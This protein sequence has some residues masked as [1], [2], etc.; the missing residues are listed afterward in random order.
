MNDVSHA[1]LVKV[2]SDVKCETSKVVNDLSL[3]VVN[4]V[5][6]CIVTL[7]NKGNLLDNSGCS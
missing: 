1:E 4:I 3:R 2:V 5:F 7:L 6:N